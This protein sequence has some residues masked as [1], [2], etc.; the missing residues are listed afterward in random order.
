MNLRLAGLAWIFAIHLAGIYLFTKGF[1]LM[2]LSLSDISPKSEFPATHK[3]AIFL[4][5]DALRFDF[6]SPNPPQPPS[7]YYHN[8]LT[9][10]SRLT[11]RHP[12]HSFIFNA[13]ADPPTTTL[14]RIKGLTTGSL[15]TFIDIGNNLGASSISEDSIMVQLQRAGRKVC[16]NTRYGS[17]CLT[18][19]QTAFMGDDTW[20]SVFPE[21]FNKS[22]PFDSFNVE[23]L[24]TVDEGV[25]ENLFP[26]MGQFDFI[27][28]HFLGVD[29][30]GHRVG[31]D[32][33]SMKAKL[34]QM[35]DVLERVVENMDEETLLVVL[36]DHGMD[37]SGDHGGDGV[38]ETSTAMWLYSKGPALT[39]NPVPSGLL[40]FKTFPGT[41][42]PHRAIQQIDLI[43]T[44]S[45]LL[46]LPI[47][48]NNLGSVI[49]E[50]FGDLQTALQLNAKQ[51]YKYLQTYRSSPSGGELDESWNAIQQAWAAAQSV[52][53]GDVKLVALNNFNRVAL[54][55]CRSMWAQFNPTLMGMGL[56]VLGMGLCASW[57]MFV[58][59]SKS[60]LKWSKWLG[61]HIPL[62]L[63]VGAGGAVV[64]AVLSFLPF[65]GQGMLDYVIFAAALASSGTM[66]VA[67]PP[68]TSLKSILS[69]PVILILH[70]LAFFSNSFIFW[71][72]RIVPF[73][74]VSSIAPFALKGFTAATTRLRYRIIGFSVLYAL[75]VRL[76][77]LSTICREEQ[78]PYCH[79]TFYASSSQTSPPLL[80]A[81]LSLPTALAL[82]LV[83]TRFLK[84]SKSDSGVAKTYYPALFAP[85]I[86]AG[87][88]TWILEWAETT[89]ALGADGAWV[90]RL[91]R[92][93]VARFA[94]GWVLIMGGTLWVVVPLCVDVSVQEKQVQVIGF[95]NALG[96]PYLV[97]WSIFLS[98]VWTTSQLPGQLMLGLATVALLAYLEVLDSVRDVKE[99]EMAFKSATPSTVLDPTKGD[100]SAPLKFTDVV[101]VTLL[102][103]HAFYATGHQSTIS[104]IQWKA[105]FLVTSTVSYPW[106]AFTVVINSIGPI[107]LFALAAPLLVLWNRAPEPRSVVKGADAVKAGGDGEVIESDARVKGDGILAGLSVMTYYASLLLGTSVSAAIL[108]RH[109]MVW[110]IF[111]PRFMAAVLGVL[112]VDVAV[113]FGEG[114]GVERVTKRVSEFFQVKGGEKSQD[115]EE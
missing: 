46:G 98:I 76:M 6:V 80:A 34:L 85:S 73:L 70:T 115:K 96:S 30:V 26:S 55:S 12:R 99:M 104:S 50:L 68:V 33:P 43:P 57:A 38:L 114:V 90:L 45:L 102:G 66:I 109:L 49:P 77:S 103:L 69:T 14:Q 93:W 87:T 112:A 78:Q 111:A 51:I 44:L 63:Q 7:P 92:S 113:L 86:I 95:G 18:G 32:H 84:I 52:D 4:I 79:V 58:G 106:S 89:N 41:T 64:G 83:I 97:F 9:L 40:Q 59:V 82:P 100:F 56:I 28:G 24:H 37:R 27:V 10:P 29:H 15:P 16:L 67:S 2:R 61:H 36:G 48:F 11:E 47:P 22:F 110:K 62:C 94:F 91:A 35:N 108:R 5:I 60:G 31:P 17:R 75:C 54:S 8:I 81:L 13:Y 25:I 19:E 88:M 53:S 65:E 1:L 74:A 3:R 107:F 20:M 39:H 23:D 101:P 21:S 105:A 72:D 42:Q 71:E